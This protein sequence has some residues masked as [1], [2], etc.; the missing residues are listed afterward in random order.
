MSEFE[1]VDKN[2]EK[3]QSTPEAGTVRRE[4]SDVNGPQGGMLPDSVSQKI[5]SKRGSGTRLTPEQNKK[6]SGEFGRDMS[7]VRIHNDPESNAISQALNARAFTIGA[8]VFLSKGIDPG[9]SQRDQKTLTHELTHVVQQNGQAGSGPLRLGAAHTT[10]EHEAEATAEGRGGVSTS[11][12]D[13]VQRGFWSDFGSSLGSGVGHMLLKQFGLDGFEDAVKDFTSSSD[14]VK[15]AEKKMKANNEDWNAYQEV[16]GNYEAKA[17]ELDTLKKDYETKAEKYE[18]EQEK[19]IEDEKKARKTGGHVGAKV[20]DAKEVNEAKAKYESAYQQHEDACAKRLTLLKK[21]DDTI[22]QE[23]I[24]KKDTG[25]FKMAVSVFFAGLA[26]GVTT[27]LAQDDEAAAGDT[28]KILAAREEKKKKARSQVNSW[29]ASKNKGHREKIETKER[30]S[31]LMDQIDDKNA[32]EEVKGYE[33]Q[34]KDIIWSAYEDIKDEDQLKGVNITKDVLWSKV[35]ASADWTNAG[36]LKEQ[37]DDVMAIHLIGTANTANADL[38]AYK[39]AVSDLAKAKREINK[40][41]GFERAGRLKFEKDQAVAA[42]DALQARL[43]AFDNKEAAEHGDGVDITLNNVT[44]KLTVGSA[45][46]AV[47]TAEQ[48]KTHAER[49]LTAKEA[50]VAAAAPGSPALTAAKQDRDLQRT[51][52]DE[53]TAA[54]QQ[55]KDFAAELTRLIGVWTGLINGAARDDLAAQQRTAAQAR[56]EKT[57][58]YTAEDANL[59][60]TAIAN[61]PA[62]SD[63]GHYFADASDVKSIAHAKQIIES[64]RGTARRMLAADSF[65]ESLS[66]VQINRLKGLIQDTVMTV[67]Q[68]V[69][70]EQTNVK[71]ANFEA[72]RDAIARSICESTRDKAKALHFYFENGR[73]PSDKDLDRKLLAGI[74]QTAEMQSFWNEVKSKAGEAV[75]TRMK[76]EEAQKFVDQGTAIFS[77]VLDNIEKGNAGPGPEKYPA[78][79]NAEVFNNIGKKAYDRLPADLQAFFGGADNEKFTNLFNAGP[80]AQYKTNIINMTNASVPIEL[81]KEASELAEKIEK[82]EDSKNKAAHENKE[83]KPLK[84]GQ[85]KREKADIIKA[86][87]ALVQKDAELKDTYKNWLRFRTMITAKD[88]EFNELI[89]EGQ[90]ESMSEKEIAEAIVEA[91]KALKEGKGDEKK[92]DAKADAKK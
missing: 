83:N 88:S 26:G 32:A 60:N 57:N 9:R 48:E 55:A 80:L 18:D 44:K 75:N 34:Y 77:Q 79:K 14:K 52:V 51:V 17:T 29:F 71:V 27:T 39:N 74:K 90:N 76:G 58:N 19:Q 25:K 7:D 41:P 11:A 6:Y 31:V 73:A 24:D 87:F 72:D 22:T 54:L 10:Q 13:T 16:T 30:K 69:K 61:A 15:A 43:A 81:D 78:G 85:R 65:L 35:T 38:T 23:D 67:A 64:K 8:D 3:K 2:E 89:E 40:V 5:Q 62:G 66:D 1:K 47:T 56:T 33:D 46:T 45:A 49:D 42:D 70:N 4:L 37:F 36:G 82:Q 12:S 59:Y 20:I 28:K 91:L 92:E 53:K 84:E 21:Y 68:T 63:M 50:A 86:A